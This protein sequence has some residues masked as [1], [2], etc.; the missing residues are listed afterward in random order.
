MFQDVIDTFAI[1]FMFALRI[2][3]PIVLTLA[4]G[5]WLEKKLAPRERT[6]QRARTAKIIQIHCWEIKKCENA[7]RAHCAAYQHSELPC[8]LAR[9]VAG[10]KVGP[11][12]YACAFYKPERMA[13]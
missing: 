10:D 13:A 5:Y 1:G 12:C 11:E 8:W 4:A 6:P 7:R 9:Q 3:L 2:G